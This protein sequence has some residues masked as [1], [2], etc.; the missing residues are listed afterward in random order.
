MKVSSPRIINFMPKVSACLGQGWIITTFLGCILISKSKVE[1]KEHLL[2]VCNCTCGAIGL[3][4][5]RE[6]QCFGPMGLYLAMNRLA[7]IAS[8][9][10][11]STDTIQEL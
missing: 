10:I 11:C 4:I 6:S 3:R 2:F 9:P 7:I 8:S 5:R 1:K